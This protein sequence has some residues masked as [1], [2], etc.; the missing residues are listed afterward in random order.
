M[1]RPDGKPVKGETTL[2]DIK[3]PARKIRKLQ[4]R[5]QHINEQIAELRDR[6]ELIDHEITMLTMLQGGGE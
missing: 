2:A 1:S 6:Q 4:E 5:R 3:D